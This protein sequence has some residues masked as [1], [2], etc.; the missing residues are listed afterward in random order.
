MPP[1]LE[2]QVSVYFSFTCEYF[3]LNMLAIISPCL[4]VIHFGEIASTPGKSKSHTSYYTR[5][6][7]FRKP[8][9]QKKDAR[10]VGGASPALRFWIPAKDVRE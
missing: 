10:Q 7:S 4:F 1:D 6:M 3:C 8:K 2:L 5:R 9:F